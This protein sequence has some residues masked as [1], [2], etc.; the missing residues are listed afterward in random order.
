MH[1]RVHG[2]G[3]A[4]R[5]FCLESPDR[6]GY[7]VEH[8]KPFAMPGIRVMETAAEVRGESILKRPYA[9]PG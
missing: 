1:I 2:H 7:I 5:P 6:D 8:A 9:Q 3:R 4:D